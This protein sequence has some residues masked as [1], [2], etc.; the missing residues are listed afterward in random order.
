MLILSN[1]QTCKFSR[2]KLSTPKLI[3]DYFS[4]RFIRLVSFTMVAQIEI[5]KLTRPPIAT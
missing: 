1:D 3:L 4:N 2:G 5:K